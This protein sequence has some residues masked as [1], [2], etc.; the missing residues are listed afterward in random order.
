MRVHTTRQNLLS[1]IQDLPRM[2]D[3]TE[4]PPSPSSKLCAFMV[5]GKNRIFKKGS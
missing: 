1:D 4:Y 3:N 5:N 2:R